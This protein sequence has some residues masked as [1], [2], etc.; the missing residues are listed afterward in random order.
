MTLVSVTSE[1]QLPTPEELDCQI[2]CNNLSALAHLSRCASPKRKRTKWQCEIPQACT[3]LLE[4]V[5]FQEQ[6]HAN[7][8]VPLNSVNVRKVYFV[9]CHDIFC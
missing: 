4:A 2:S 5:V 7:E 8:I 3:R 1:M 9:F 6:K